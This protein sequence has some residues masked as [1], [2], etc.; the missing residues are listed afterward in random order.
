MLINRFAVVLCLLAAPALAGPPSL[1]WSQLHA[2]T[3]GGDNQF[4]G[5][6][7]DA[8]GYLNIVY[9]GDNS[10]DNGA[11]RVVRYDNAGNVQGALALAD[12]NDTPDY[13]TALMLDGSGNYVVAGRGSTMDWSQ[14]GAAKYNPVTG[15]VI[16]ATLY[17]ES[18]QNYDPSGAG[19]DAGGN[20]YVL[21]NTRDSNMPMEGH[22]NRLHPL[23]LKVS[24]A[25]DILWARTISGFMMGSTSAYGEAFAVNPAGG[26]YVGGGDIKWSFGM[27]WSVD[28]DGGVSWS[29]S[30]DGRPEHL[31]LALNSLYAFYRNG[32]EY[33]GQVGF[34][35]FTTAG[36]QL[37][38][39]SQAPWCTDF[40]ISGSA[41]DAG[42]TG[43]VSGVMQVPSGHQSGFLMKINAAV[44]AT[45]WGQTYDFGNGESTSWSADGVVLDAAGTPHLVTNLGGSTGCGGCRAP[46][47]LLVR[48]VEP[49]AGSAVWTR[50]YDY[51][52]VPSGRD[53]AVDS[54]GNVYM[55]TDKPATLV[56]YTSG[57]AL[58]WTR[59]YANPQYCIERFGRVV[60]R[61]GEEYVSASVNLTRTY[62]G[63]GKSQ[64]ALNVAAYQSTGA[65]AFDDFTW[66]PPW[67]E[68][69]PGPLACSAGG[70]IFVACATRTG[71]GGSTTTYQ[72][73]VAFSAVGTVM[74]TRTVG[75]VGQEQNSDIPGIGVDAGANVYVLGAG[76]VGMNTVM[77]LTKMDYGGNWL[78]TKDV[79]GGL[80]FSYPT[81][82]AVDAAAG[83]IYLSAAE[84][85]NIQSPT[86]L[87]GA[88]VGLDTD[89]NVV[90][91]RSNNGGQL[92]LY[93]DVAVNASGTVFVTGT[94]CSTVNLASQQQGIDAVGTGDII[95]DAYDPTDPC[96]APAWS[97]R[98]DS[99]LGDDSGVAVAAGSV[100]VI[101]TTPQGPRIFKYGEGSADPAV[102]AAGVTISPAGP[103]EVNTKVTV[104][105]TVTDTGGR[106]AIG[107]AST[108]MLSSGASAFWP[109]RGPW[110]SGPPD[111]VSGASRTWYWTTT[112]A[113]AGTAQLT[114]T[115]SGTDACSG[116]VVRGASALTIQ[117]A[118]KSVPV[119]ALAVTRTICGIGDWV[120][121]DLT[122]T[123]EGIASATVNGLT[124][125]ISISSWVPLEWIA[126]MNQTPVTVSAG[127]K[128]V[129]S[130]T[131]SVSGASPG[132]IGFTGQ[133]VGTD[134][135]F[136]VLSTSA[137][138]SATL[139]SQAKLSATV[140][141][142]G[143]TSV[144]GVITFNAI[145]TN[146]GAFPAVGVTATV[147]I[148]TGG[149]TM[150]ISSPVPSV[151][152]TILAGGSTQ[153]V[154]T[155]TATGAGPGTFTVS[156][157]GTDGSTLGYPLFARVVGGGTIQTAAV[158]TG[159][160]AV[161]A[162]TLEVGQTFMRTFTVTNSGQAS[163]VNVQQ[164]QIG[165]GTATVTIVGAGA[166]PAGCTTLGGGQTIVYTMTLAG[167]TPGTY[168]QT[169]TVTGA[170][171]NTNYPLTTGCIVSS[172][173][174]ILQKPI[175]QGALTAFR[176]TGGTQA[177]LGQGFLVMLTVTN[178]GGVTAAGVLPAVFSFSGTG[179]AS[180]VGGANPSGPQSI[181]AGASLVFTWTFA[182]SAPGSLAFSTSATGFSTMSGTTAYT[183][184][185]W[186]N[187][188]TLQ[189][190]LSSSAT[191][192]LASINGAQTS[193]ITM[194]ISNTGTST[195]ALIM[196]YLA[197]NPADAA[198]TVSGPTATD[199]T[200]A[201]GESATVSW[202]MRG[203]YAAT[204]SVTAYVTALDGF[205]T[206]YPVTTSALTVVVVNSSL[207]SRA[208]V[209][210]AS[211]YVGDPFRVEL[212]VTQGGATLIQNVT[213]SMTL[214]HPDYAA[215]GPPSPA[216]KGS[217]SGGASVTF[218]WTG[219]GQKVG[220]LTISVAAAGTPLAGSYDSTQQ[221][222][223]LTIAARPSN[224]TP[225][226]P[227]EPV[228]PSFEGD[229]IVY[230][231]PVSGDSVS[232]AIR[233]RAAATSIMMD[234]YNTAYQR[235]WNGEFPAA[236][237]GDRVLQVAGVSRWA[238]GVYLVR[239]RA[240]RADGGAQVFPTLRIG[241][242]R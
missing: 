150:V 229:A 16:W 129:F 85:D 228:A 226:T 231:N 138:G 139:L 5:G 225:T 182:G 59:S 173:V 210:P 172:T 82:M 22:D 89:G 176:S 230:P 109:L 102:L 41:V 190:L 195:A 49:A 166:N 67:G 105:L 25:G 28:T 241:V 137:V 40:Q 204:V 232:L 106:T 156:V 112:A 158:L 44:T 114:A 78:W 11:L 215:V 91:T 37:T 10:G 181:G 155:M 110:T 219:A 161:Y 193:V 119:S 200:L 214:D 197:M 34:Q 126:G 15:A 149:G 202:G 170:D 122:V 194:T 157:T 123:N 66:T 52:P 58:A 167:S 132:V 205:D 101:G 45:L 8:S 217:L 144:G 131:F 2:P 23:I 153:F 224:T 19:M 145:V 147:M 125:T 207:K 191:A 133:A 135:V 115:G 151:P 130:W 196:P 212:T 48:R 98:W 95:V 216:I 121:V 13:Q 33:G 189:P 99:G 213:P 178:T 71:T 192:S 24:P 104:Y 128:Q 233:L 90:W 69:E 220:T 20:T 240:F 73:V 103:V 72:S 237:A 1:L 30:I 4:G 198:T 117:A 116:S 26:C 236:S 143:V 188:M 92:M 199:L 74:W 118:Y 35:R 27:L 163:A 124:A 234:V 141:T 159:S 242:K 55:L 148:S 21:T 88:V 60:V 140:P 56:K 239:I 57:G 83:R 235:V 169:R 32:N 63:D 221:T 184:A 6:V 186:S 211:I 162:T 111:L 175:L 46:A 80:P 31:T 86:I 174:M 3:A 238:P 100:A 208:V 164:D 9:Y 96:P 177:H 97:A 81:G 39:I 206:S 61:G 209:S 171:V 51:A 29:V 65:A 43:Y 187:A 120:K 107:I 47:D 154:W 14:V 183:G 18:S 54:S 36:A 70:D 185:A 7:F 218:S 75:M 203:S 68:V 76:T 84:S 146:T 223:V 180:P 142:G 201:P 93:W 87:R 53:L 38:G 94:I 12:S 165:W 17:L 64:R 222:I 79:T 42:G 62:C 227:E 179:A 50:Q 113:G 136:G 127:N 134:P 160:Y 168:W 77:R 108:L 152:V